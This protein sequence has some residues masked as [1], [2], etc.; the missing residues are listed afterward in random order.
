MYENANNAGLDYNTGREK[1]LVPEFGR[2]VLKMVEQLKEID[3]RAKRT[4]QAAAIVKVMEIL[5]PQVRQQEDYRGL[6]TVCP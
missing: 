5:N 3:D 4:E 1:L 2:N 6:L